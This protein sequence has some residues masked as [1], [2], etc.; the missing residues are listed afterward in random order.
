LEPEADEAYQEAECNS[1]QAYVPIGVCLDPKGAEAKAQYTLMHYKSRCRW[2]L[3]Q[4]FGDKRQV[5]VVGKPTASSQE[6]EFIARE[7][8]AKL[9]S[10]L[11][12]V[13][14]KTW[15]KAQLAVL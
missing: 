1:A 9:N 8:L 11:D 5:L 2:G 10:G 7:C 13:E 15:S 14:V 6:V 12:P 4:K 3:R